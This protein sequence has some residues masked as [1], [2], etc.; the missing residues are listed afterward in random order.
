MGPG[1]YRNAVASGRR[2]T[3]M[4]DMSMDPTLTRYGT[5]PDPLCNAYRCPLRR[6]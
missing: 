2:P 6:G 4:R 1:Q 3:I 5:D